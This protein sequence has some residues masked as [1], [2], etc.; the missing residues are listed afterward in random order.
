MGPLW[1]RIE[2][3]HGLVGPLR[4][5]VYRAGLAYLQGD[6]VVVT[7]ALKGLGW[8]P[9][10]PDLRLGM[11]ETVRWYQRAGWVPDY[12]ALPEEDILEEGIHLSYDEHFACGYDRQGDL[13]LT[14][15]F[16]DVRKLAFG[17]DASIQG[18]LSIEGLCKKAALKGTLKVFK[19]RRD[20]L[21]EFTFCGD[22]GQGYRFSGRKHL[23]LLGMVADFARLEGTVV[24][25]RGQETAVLRWRM[26]LKED[27]TALIKSVRMS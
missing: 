21:Y 7:D 26:S 10:W 15:T 5:N 12:H 23:T 17:Q 1:K 19:A 8:S 20:M 14:V 11:A 27:L 18:E 25:T 2:E 13:S 4:P 24:N 16:P 22:D 9:R 3:R 6:R